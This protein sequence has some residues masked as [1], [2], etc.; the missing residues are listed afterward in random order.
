MIEIILNGEKILLE[1]D[2]NVLEFL[3]SRNYN[4][5]FVAVEKDR[6]ILQK[7]LWDKTKISTGKIYEIVEFVGGG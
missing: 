4:L 2:Q 1:K 7:K 6:E 3:T 5:N